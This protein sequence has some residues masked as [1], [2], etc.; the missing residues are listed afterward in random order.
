MFYWKINPLSE[1]QKK[2]QLL[3][4]YSIVGLLHNSG[5]HCTVILGKAQSDTV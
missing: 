5:I 2:K 1:K 3:H 4:Y